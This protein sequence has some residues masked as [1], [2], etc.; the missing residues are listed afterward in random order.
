MKSLHNFF[1]LTKAARNF[2]CSRSFFDK[3][4]DGINIS[5]K[6]VSLSSKMLS[7]NT[8]SCSFR[9]SALLNYFIVMTTK[10]I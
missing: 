9:S 3:N 10:P 2:F 4:Q 7:T 6:L 5:Y 8:I 1:L